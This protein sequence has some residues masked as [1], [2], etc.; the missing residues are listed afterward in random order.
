MS[1]QENKP[2]PPDGSER[3]SGGT[4]PGGD[5][6]FNWKGLLWLS[7]ALSLIATGVMWHSTPP[8]KPLP[9]TEFIALLEKG[10]INKEKGV[11][12]IT[13]QGSA[14]D[15]IS[16]FLNN[17]PG[18]AVALERKTQVNLALVAKDLNEKLEKQ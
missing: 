8:G 15:T 3:R 1:N 11:K 18:A 7:I 10:E 13:S 5:Q 4:G 16:S 9:Y 12:V 17:E 6:S 2:T 14:L